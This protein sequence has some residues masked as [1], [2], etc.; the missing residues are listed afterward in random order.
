MGV[1]KKKK[2]PNPNFPKF[3]K[4]KKIGKDL[5]YK[6]WIMFLKTSNKLIKLFNFFTDYINPKKKY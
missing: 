4:N 3:Q 2:K 6:L 1:V 5:K